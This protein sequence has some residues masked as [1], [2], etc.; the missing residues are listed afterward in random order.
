MTEGV[1]ISNPAVCIPKS[2]A[3]LEE[4][5]VFVSLTP[6][7]PNKDTQAKYHTACHGLGHLKQADPKAILGGKEPS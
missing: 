2:I 7:L 6:G 3:Q 4:N 1:E 5:V